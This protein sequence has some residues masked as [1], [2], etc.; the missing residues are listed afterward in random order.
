MKPEGGQTQ[1][2]GRLNR[3]PASESQIG[4]N[5]SLS[6]AEQERKAADRG[7]T[8]DNLGRPSTNKIH[9]RPRRWSAQATSSS[10]FIALALAAAIAAIVVAVGYDLMHDL[11]DQVP[12]ALSG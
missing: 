6:T 2:H 1:Q 4:V 11:A 12:P 7:A 9:G 8:D 5:A 10:A 3:A